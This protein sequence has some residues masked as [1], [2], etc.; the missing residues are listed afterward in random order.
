MT[1]AIGEWYTKLTQD[2]VVN[3]VVTSVSGLKMTA[4]QSAGTFLADLVLNG[5]FDQAIQRAKDAAIQSQINQVKSQVEDH[6][7]ATL[8]S[9]FGIHSDKT[10]AAYVGELFG[11]QQWVGNF[12]VD[13]AKTLGEQL[14]E[15][16]FDDSFASQVVTQTAINFGIGQGLAIA[17]GGLKGGITGALADGLGLADVVPLG[18]DPLTIAASIIIE[19]LLNKAFSHQ[20][21]EV[22]TFIGDVG[23]DVWDFVRDPVNSIKD[24]FDDPKFRSIDGTVGDDT[25]YQPSR[26][27]VQSDLKAGNDVMFGGDGWG[28][29]LGGLGDDIITNG[30]PIPGGGVP[31]NGI[32][33]LYGEEGADYID[34]GG[35]NDELYGGGGADILYGGA[36][37]DVL[38]GGDASPARTY[39][40]D[41]G[42]DEGDYLDGGLGNDTYTGGA[43]RDTFVITLEPGAVD[44]ITDFHSGEDFID[45]SQF[46]SINDFGDV[47][48]AVENAQTVLVLPDNQRVIL[49]HV[50]PT[51]LSR[52]DFI[53]TQ[54]GTSGPD[55]LLGSDAV[56]VFNGL[57]GNDD[58]RLG[59]GNDVANGNQGDDQ[60]AGGAGDDQ[61][62]GGQDND[63]ITG[64]E[65]NDDLRGDLGDDFLNG[66]Q[67][68]DRVDGGAGN[69]QV[70][71][72]RGDD[73]VLG[74]D[75][76]DQLIGDLGNDVLL[77]GHGADDFVITPDPGS[78]D[79]I[80]DF[81]LG[82]GDRLVLSGFVSSPLTADNFA[83]VGYDVYVTF[84][85]NQIE[86]VRFANLQDIETALGIGGNA[87]FENVGTPDDQ[88]PP[89]ISGLTG[90]YQTNQNAVTVQPFSGA[91]FDDA[92]SPDLSGG[93]M[94]V[95]VSSGNAQL[96]L[97]AALGSLNS[98]SPSSGPSNQIV[99]LGQ[100]VLWNGFDV[101]GL[102]ISADQRTLTLTFSANA[103]SGVIQQVLNDVAAT[104]FSS[105]AGIS[106][107]FSDGDGAQSLPFTQNLQPDATRNAIIGNPSVSDVT[108]NVN[109]DANGLLKANGTI[110][111]ADPDQGGAQF[112][113][114]VTS[115]A[116]NLGTLTLASNGAYTY[117]VLN[118]AIQFLGEGETRVE[119]FLIKALDGTTKDV[120]FTIHGIDNGT[121][122]LTGATLNISAT[123]VADT[124]T[125][126]VGANLVI[127]MNGVKYS[128]APGLITVV[129]IHGNSGSDSL[130]FNGSSDNES[131]TFHPG[132]LDVAGTG[133]AIHS[134]GFENVRAN[135]GGGT[136]D[137]AYLYDSAGNDSLI[138][139]PSYTQLTGSGFTSYASGFDYVY[140]YATAGTSGGI[141]DKASFFDSA[142]NDTLT[143]TPAYSQL[144]GPG[145][146]NYA[147]SFDQV[148]A[149][150]T[151]GGAGDRANLFDSAG[152]DT[153]IGTP[154]YSLLKGTGYYN[155]VQSFDQVSAYAT[156]G[157]A[158]GAGDIASLY[159]S[160]GND[161]LTETPL[162]SLLKGAGFY[163]YAQ[164]F[165]QVFAYASAGNAGGPG[166]VASLYD[167][168]GNDTL[169][170]KPAQTQLSGAGYSNNAF[171]FGRVTAYATA[172]DTGGA[173]DRAYLYDSTGN[174]VLTS[175]PVHSI[176]SGSGYWNDAEHFDKVYAYASTDA[177]GT[178]DRAYLYDSAGNDIL[179]ATPLY[180]QL[181]GS[182]YF[183][184]A[185]RFDQVYAYASGDAGGTGDRAN[186]FDSAGNDTLTATPT[187]AQLTG[188]GF[189]NYASRFDQ[190]YAYASTD[191][192]GTG[193]RAN[194]FD[195]AGNDTLTATPTYSL[196]KGLGFY[197]YAQGFDKASA[198]AT[199][200]N[201]GGVGDVANLY[202]SA[203]SDKLFA[204]S[205]YAWIQGT[206][207]YNYVRGFQHV[208]GYAVAGGD[209]TLDVGSIL[210]DFHRF[211]SWEHLL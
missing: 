151:A 210:Y 33:E 203:G 116:G 127:W 167:S 125:V 96:A 104:N 99:L 50:P 166:D 179:T 165:N 36:G 178:G 173:G 41:T 40:R 8:T 30:D 181:T 196:L 106:I 195:S 118:S 2:V 208:N 108:E 7:Q 65:G 157:D 79:S 112:Q 92:D 200:G 206:G 70:R 164:S 129:N 38:S 78:T 188:A 121:V 102:Q 16:K 126:T 162:F 201:A 39:T 60:I 142:G 124:I 68:N 139:T 85:G 148:Y 5:D 86:V 136:N 161:M 69:D 32:G 59:G 109:V 53:F 91:D 101:G 27:R 10:A 143:A 90:T 4:S 207:F 193:D 97:D 154:T 105:G 72:G 172:G 175:T 26:A 83:Q 64:G 185:S 147:A 31:G 122:G 119:S 17:T 134:D 140:A 113:T 1:G 82:D 51:G 197:N 57:Q 12:A 18:F 21:A 171:K 62:R 150:A 194:L 42:P 24:L 55:Q 149:Y 49:N 114:V 174:D 170:S 45:L 9:A 191:A 190:V 110:S 155:Y 145:Y 177:G 22:E 180:A 186:L 13:L 117:S 77:G 128:Y 76:D 146:F 205:D 29:V 94:V 130:T 56:E 48:I 67:G 153:F 43:G 192:G 199:A 209:D 74:G 54:Y 15:G 202:D 75:G 28:V 123:S 158:G 98:S 132:K 168:T 120:S 198:Y 63:T 137:R 211:G 95:S 52:G 183:N 133:F 160:A 163:N 11:N 93:Q 23:E 71:G 35:G 81:S 115:D 184:Y 44:T 144:S 20:I 66:N 138:A 159:D 131:V 84:P 187:Y 141:G 189:L 80:Q 3:G 19:T 61:L 135:S 88:A 176:L 58:L 152:N 46:H 204:R 107:Q 34:A 100:R 87:N 103:T 169:I 37:N 6:L 47:Q 25:L 89:V 156:A 73:L 182:G 111:I 14:I